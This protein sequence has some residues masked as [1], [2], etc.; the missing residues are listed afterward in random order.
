M[1][2]NDENPK[3][4]KPNSGGDETNINNDVRPDPNL[5]NVIPCHK[6]PEHTKEKQTANKEKKN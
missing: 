2:E 5:E 6:P 1:P 3:P 4:D